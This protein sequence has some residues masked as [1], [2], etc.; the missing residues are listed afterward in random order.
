MWRQRSISGKFRGGLICRLSLTELC[1]PSYQLYQIERLDQCR[2]D[3]SRILCKLSFVQAWLKP[4]NTEPIVRPEDLRANRPQSSTPANWPTAPHGPLQPVA[5]YVSKIHPVAE[6][7][8]I[9]VSVSSMFNQVLNFKIDVLRVSIR[10]N[11][12]DHGI[13]TRSSEHWTLFE[14]G[15]SS[16]T[17]L[18]VIRN[19]IACQG[20]GKY[21]MQPI[22]GNRRH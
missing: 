20:V 11:K 6:K 10:T 9:T 22:S 1:E 13:M 15:R 12:V 19:V 16:A 14:H 2:S 21:V 7:M 18:L 4:D 5:L 3:I 8:D 17:S